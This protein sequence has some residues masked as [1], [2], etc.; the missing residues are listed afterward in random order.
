[1]SDEEFA[2]LLDGLEI[3]DDDATAIAERIEQMRE[4]AREHP[5]DD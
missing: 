4:L 5:A 1:M 2:A 3:D